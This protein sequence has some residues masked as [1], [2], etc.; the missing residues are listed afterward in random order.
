MISLDTEGKAFVAESFGVTVFRGTLGE[1]PVLL[2]TLPIDQRHPTRVDEFEGCL[3]RWEAADSH[4]VTLAKLLE[5]DRQEGMIQALFVDS[6]ASPLTH[7]LEFQSTDALRQR[8]PLFL[9]DWERL[10]V[11]G[12]TWFHLD[13]RLIFVSDES[14]VVCAPWLLGEPG[15]SPPPGAAVKEDWLP[16]APEMTRRTTLSVDRRSGFYSLGTIFYKTTTGRWPVEHAEPLALISGILN[17]TPSEQNLDFNGPVFGAI[18]KRL[19][20]KAPQDRYQTLRGLE[21]DLAHLTEGFLELGTR[22]NPLPL[23][24]LSHLF[25][26][27]S[28]LEQ[29]RGFAPQNDQGLMLFLTGE[30]GIGKSALAEEYLK[31]P[32]NRRIQWFTAKYEERNSSF[33]NGALVRALSQCLGNLS[34]ENP[35]RF[36]AVEQ[37]LIA[38]LG[39]NLQL[40]SPLF[41]ILSGAASNVPPLL[42]IP[43]DEQHRRFTSAILSLLEA[44]AITPL[45]F[46]LEDLHWADELTWELLS[47]LAVTPRPRLNLVLTSRPNF[48]S[49]GQN[50][51]Q[52]LG[53]SPQGKVL[54]LS[55]LTPVVLNQVIQEIAD[56][57]PEQQRTLARFLWNLSQGNPLTLGLQVQEINRKGLIMWNPASE[58]WQLNEKQLSEMPFH[59]AETLV[60]QRLK[61][62]PEEAKH[63]VQMASVLESDFSTAEV[64]ALA[65]VPETL[66]ETVTGELVEA[67]L[68]ERSGLGA[69][70]PHDR[71]RGAI[72]AQISPSTAQR[73]HIKVGQQRWEQLKGGQAVL[74]SA[75]AI[76]WNRAQDVLSPEQKQFLVDLNFQAGRE[77]R[78]QND[79]DGSYFFW[80]C[81]ISG[82]GQQLWQDNPS[83]AFDLYLNATETASILHRV[84]VSD[85]WAELAFQHAPSP[86]QK[87]QIRERQQYLRFY[88][89]DMPGSLQ[90]GFQ[91]LEVL[92]VKLN[93]A[94]S[95]LSVLSEFVAVKFALGRRQPDEVARLPE[96]QKP[97]SRITMLLLSGFIPTAFNTSRQS[98]FGLA[99][100][101]AFRLTLKDGLCP[102]SAPS[103]TGYAMLLSAMGSFR[104]AYDWA[105]FALALN[106]HF[107]DLTWR[108]MVMTLTGL[109]AKGWF[110]PWDRLKTF[111]EAA[112]VASE[113]SG[114]VLYRNYTYL[115]AAL[116]NPS[117]DLPRQQRALEEA[118]TKTKK[119]QF[120]LTK[121]SNSVNLAAL[122][123]LAFQ[124]PKVLDFRYDDVDPALEIAK[125]RQS[126][127]LSVIAAMYSTMLKTACLFCETEQAQ[128]YLQ[129]AWALRSSIAGSLYEEELMLY[130]G[131]ALSLNF[132]STVF[133]CHTRRNILRI[134]RSKARRWAQNSSQFSFHREVL[135]GIA[136]QSRHLWSSAASCLSRAIKAADEAGFY[137][138]QALARELLARLW[139]AQGLDVPARLLH[140]QA[141][142]R[143]KR[144]G[145]WALL[146]AL[147]EKQEPRQP[148]ALDVVSIFKAIEAISGEIDLEALISSILELVM[149]NSGADRA[150]LFS[151][152][153]G[154][155][156]VIGE[157]DWGNTIR[158]PDQRVAERDD[159]PQWI[160][161]QSIADRKEVIVEEV[162]DIVR[163][164]SA[165]LSERGVC[166]F[167]GVPLLSNG[168]VTAYLYLENSVMPG[169]LTKERLQVV[170]R[171][172]TPMAM[173]LQNARLFRDLTEAKLTLERRVEER[174]QELKASQ[175]KIILQEKLA[176]LGALTAGI[177]H[178]LKNPLNLINNFAESSVE[179]I[180]ELEKALAPV[181]PQLSDELQSEL[182]Y[183][184]PELVQNMHDIKF[185]GQR[186]DGIIRSMLL[187]SR[188]DAGHAT[189]EDLNGLVKEALNLSYHGHRARDKNFSCNLRENLAEDIPPV[190]IIRPNLGRV[191]TNLF[192]NAFQALSQRS[193]EETDKS[194]VPEVT[195]TTAVHEQN[196]HIVIE[197]NGPGIPPEFLDKIF[198][199]FFTTKPPGEGTGLGLSLS[200]DIIK[201]EINGNLSV[202]STLRKMT[203][204]TIIFPYGRE[205][206]FQE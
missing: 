173:A 57:E 22:D 172:A 55:P 179:L 109:F 84:E 197:D 46:L 59:G 74:P 71:I 25:G 48:G 53:Q 170:E 205:G 97:V 43:P 188:T 2:A 76:H 156:K 152:D 187:H 99:V 177:A 139:S 18:T 158:R 169:I 86:L 202:K 75:I 13:P 115:F 149:E 96:N 69:R 63:T 132:K 127:N 110:E 124:R 39:R 14:F 120:P 163:R 50:L 165:V 198:H 100:L 87:A 94:P 93:E 28:E 145:A 151:T 15:S 159:L 85:K 129:E 70:F 51:V 103:F 12:L 161:T 72:Y 108:P 49:S 183:L 67:G 101:K 44:S 64:F 122:R 162:T 73:F 98:L 123:L 137:E 68:W 5:W 77:A 38:V 11:L 133:A 105:Q 164:Q 134:A 181:R 1:R 62:L 36:S 24:E 189:W 65:E 184:L 111:Y 3:R 10:E 42:P 200:Y 199:P 194:W 104:Q 33:A 146:D 135:E 175:K 29:L 136:F 35:R 138:W 83:Q 153:N 147:P 91:G 160:L 174:S 31:F 102:E 16:M 157:T 113:E 41:P 81:A 185:H 8:L 78:T 89:G 6:G 140:A 92:G 193:R 178:E 176:S 180:D 21:W 190:L 4:L 182:D 144:F 203:Q 171:M 20:A 88:L 168:E 9:Q 95:L 150:L 52:V 56:L 82:G 204:F 107:D 117:Q 192:N 79:L 131:V 23:R 196:I 26:R 54:S 155:W 47:E 186:G 201:A 60:E 80:E 166:S 118:L 40:L 106:Q 141:Q 206:S 191:L 119:L 126:G 32:A 58:A 30:G 90:A 61:E 128:T 7:F 143:W 195:V 116:W 121:V 142:E 45:G 27:D 37:H 148:E 154:T 66:H 19:L 114:D 34:R 17:Q 130:A 112:Q 167:I 125:F